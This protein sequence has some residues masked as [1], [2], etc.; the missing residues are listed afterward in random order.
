MTKEIL[1]PILLKLLA[2]SSRI[3]WSEAIDQA[4]AAIMELGEKTVEERLIEI[5][6]KDPVKIVNF[7]L[8]YMGKEMIKCNAATMDISQECDVE[9]KRYSVVAKCELTPIPPTKPTND[10]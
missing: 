3:S 1:K 8:I 10:E 9:G 7:L 6:K 2:E 4:A 5:L